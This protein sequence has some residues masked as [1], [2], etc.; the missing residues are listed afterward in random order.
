VRRSTHEDSQQTSSR[1]LLIDL[2]GTPRGRLGLEL[3]RLL[4]DGIRS[5]R[6]RAQTALPSTR[7]L[8]ADLRV[9]RSV[10]TL[11]YEQLA[12]EGYLVT[13]QGA[14]ARVAA[15]Q[16]RP[17]AVPGPPPATTAGDH[18]SID[19]RPGTAD[20]GSF[21]RVEW[22]RA[23][24]RSLAALPDAA[25]GYGDSRG[26]PQLR[27][28]LADYLG[29]VRGAIVDPG[30]LVVVNG[31]AQGLAIIA[32]LLRRR[33]IDAVGV[34]DPG[35]PHTADQLA[36]HDLATVGVPVDRYG[37]DIDRLP[38]PAPPPRAV[39]TTPA[40][41]FP[42][43]VILS[44]DRR[45]RLIA[46]AD[47]VDGYIIE[48]DY[49]AEYRYDH[50]PV[51]TVQGLAPGRVL[52]GGST[53]KTLAPGLRLGW[54]AVP[55]HL[56]GEAARDKRQQDLMSPVI[57]QAAFAELLTSG[58]YERHIRRNR[59]RY[60][61]RRDMLLELLGTH[62]PDAVIRGE[63]AGLHLLI[64]TPAVADE[65]A[66]VGHAA[67]HG[68]QL[69]GSATYRRAPGPAG[70]VLAYAHLNHDQLRRA[71]RILADAVA[72]ARAAR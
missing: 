28:A 62:L 29:R 36:A 12:A 20:L 65:Q 50:Q 14:P 72:A 27:E 48:D 45:R 21:P 10:V 67:R 22:E 51:A 57:E 5:G 43:G 56:S 70:F 4:R 61:R 16:L 44:A 64:D 31:F 2:S 30:D 60:K 3:Q 53:S 35:S 66:V 34:E 54:L 24:R 33:G 52:L 42:T 63:A 59:A 68:L 71:V 47:S 17:A 38:P 25:L 41:Q 8:A 37:L 32:R 18:T 1:E 49:D 15:I 46:W 39:L 26:L 6:L 9:S 13:S 55:S 19:F 69:S 23:L 40:H 11:A 58:G 7:A